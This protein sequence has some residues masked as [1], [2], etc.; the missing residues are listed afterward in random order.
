MIP[1]VGD[2]GKI[3]KYG[4]KLDKLLD[5]KFPLENPDDLVVGCKHKT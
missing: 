4:K 1:I 5:G 3:F 2:L